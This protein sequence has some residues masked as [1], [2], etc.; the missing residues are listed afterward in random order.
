MSAPPDAPAP[1][2]GLGVGM[3]AMVTVG[4]VLLI[5]GFVV[6]GAQLGLVPLYAGFLLLWYFGSID[7]L[8]TGALPALAVGAVCGTLTAWLLQYGVATW[9]PTG[10]IPG[11]VVIIAAIF[12]QL[13]GRLPIAIN[14]AYMLYLTVMAAP[15][16]QTHERFDR[17]L[18]VIAL[19]TLYFG[20]IVVIGRKLIAARQSK[21]G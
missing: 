7:V 9:G 6:L 15:L 16:L 3:A 5:V 12:V 19:A 11:L 2:A 17:V 20:G 8:E 4:L 21:A 14:R 18:L 1:A 10:S 13:L